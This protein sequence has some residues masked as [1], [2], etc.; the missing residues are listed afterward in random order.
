MDYNDAKPR[1][2]LLSVK[3][4][5]LIHKEIELPGPVWFNGQSLS[6]AVTSD[7][8]SK[9]SIQHSAQGIADA[10]PT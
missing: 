1:A 5:G 2:R 7:H 10:R 9:T 4:D 6:V 8:R 3:V